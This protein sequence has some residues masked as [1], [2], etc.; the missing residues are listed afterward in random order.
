MITT[1][2]IRT[3][4][5]HPSM[6]LTVHAV[7]GDQNTRCLELSLYASGSPFV[8]PEGVSMAM[9]YRKRDG[10]RGYYDTMPDGSS[11][12]SSEGNTITIQLAPQMLTVPGTVEA[13]LEL[14]MGEEILGTFSLFIHVAENPAAGFLRSEDYVNWLKWMKQALSDQVSQMLESGAFTGAIG[15]VGP[16]GPKGE[17]GDPGP[18]GPQ[19]EPGLSSDI[20]KEYVDSKHVTFPKTLITSGWTGSG[21][22]T[23]SLISSDILASDFPHIAPV[24]DADTATALAQQEAWAA[25]S[26]AEAAAGSILFTCFEEK[27]G[28]NIPIQVE[29]NR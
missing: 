19:G 4:L 15:P 24:Y 5:I 26:K 8:P 10:T 29:V 9:R 14:T 16:Q 7:Q 18:A 12:W 28:V 1:T 27:P 22:Y 25:V 20:T 3:D 2:K 17:K 13:Q 23:L 11:A 21:P 6:P